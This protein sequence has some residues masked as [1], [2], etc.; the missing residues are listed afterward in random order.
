M[1]FEQLR[2][3]T[4]KNCSGGAH[5][6]EYLDFSFYDWCWYNDNAGLGE[7]K[8]G[9]WLGVS[10]ESHEQLGTYPARNRHYQDDCFE[11]H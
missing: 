11:S 5:G 9:W 10:R 4:S 3:S 6:G 8:L 7:T 1:N 2:Q